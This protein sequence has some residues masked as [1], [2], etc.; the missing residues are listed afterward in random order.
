MALERERQTLR[1]NLSIFY[2]IEVPDDSEE[3][4]EYAREL[5]V[6]LAKTETITSWNITEVTPTSEINDG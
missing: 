1:V 5:A 6:E 2:D 4:W 3:S